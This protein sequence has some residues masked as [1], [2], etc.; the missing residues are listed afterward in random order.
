M[1]KT[2]S[3]IVEDSEMPPSA[4]L[5]HLVHLAELCIDLLQENNEYYAE[6]SP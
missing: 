4:K 1:S 5:E 6:V 2:T 3:E